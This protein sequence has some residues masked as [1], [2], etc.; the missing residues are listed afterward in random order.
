M[1][2]KLAVAEMAALGAAGLP[3]LVIEHPLGGEGRDGVGRRVAQ[4]VEQ[5]AGLLAPRDRVGEEVD[6]L[7]GHPDERQRREEATPHDRRESHSSVLDERQRREE[8]TPHDRRE[9][10]SSVLEDQEVYE[11]FVR[12]EWCD[13]LPIVPPTRERV[14]AMLA[15]ARADGAESFG[16]CRLCGGT[17]RSRRS[18]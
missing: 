16:S 15:G 1:F 12:R 6:R 2:Q 3:L 7:I 17:A 5:L 18:P 10:H 8:A 11:E 13:G 9:S 14:D 4:A